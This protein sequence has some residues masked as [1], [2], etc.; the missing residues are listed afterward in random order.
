MLCSLL[1]A[2]ALYVVWVITL[3]Y[4]VLGRCCILLH[5]I[6][7]TYSVGYMDRMDYVSMLSNELAYCESVETGG[8]L[9]HVVAQGVSSTS[10]ALHAT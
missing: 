5:P 4:V 9:H 10:R 3:L 2:V 8:L 6:I 1:H 7:P